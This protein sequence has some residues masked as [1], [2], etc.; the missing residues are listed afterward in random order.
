MQ[1]KNLI[2]LLKSLMIT[3]ISLIL[4]GIY[5]HLYNS[6]IEAMG[7]TGI[8]ISAACVAVGMILSIP[9]KMVVTF[10]LVNREIKQNIK[11]NP[12]H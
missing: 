7:V 2:L 3:G 10:M 1:N 6:T 12:R 8:I 4:L 9:T 11:K 5:F